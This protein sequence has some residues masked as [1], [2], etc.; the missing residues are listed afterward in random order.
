MNKTKKDEDTKLEKDGAFI[1]KI[2]EIYCEYG[3]GG[4]FIFT[5]SKGNVMLSGVTSDQNT[6]S[7]LELLKSLVNELERNRYTDLLRYKDKIFED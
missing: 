6:E 7:L 3:K 5:G 1:K 4:A 2:G